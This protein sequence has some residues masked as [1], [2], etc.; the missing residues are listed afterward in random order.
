MTVVSDTVT[1]RSAWPQHLQLLAWDSQ[2]WMGCC[3][4]ATSL[5]PSAA[6]PGAAGRGSDTQPSQGWSGCCFQG[7]AVQ[8]QRGLGAGHPYRKLPSAP[9]GCWIQR[10]PLRKECQGGSRWSP[11][12]SVAVSAKRDLVV[13]GRRERAGLCGS[14]GPPEAGT[15]MNGTLCVSRRRGLQAASSAAFHAPRRT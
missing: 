6:L 9:R 3:P 8:T 13:A 12:A 4:G 14:D 10:Q 2:S 15:W 1:E 5:E 11:A 7:R